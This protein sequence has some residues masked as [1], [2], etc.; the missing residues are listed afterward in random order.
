MSACNRW[1]QNTRGWPDRPKHVVKVKPDIEKRQVKELVVCFNIQTPGKFSVTSEQQKQTKTEDSLPM[2]T[3][4][5]L[6]Q[7]CLSALSQPPMKM[8]HNMN[9]TNC[10]RGGFNTNIVWLNKSKQNKAPKSFCRFATLAYKCV[11]NTYLV[12]GHLNQS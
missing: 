8:T 11:L 6:L 3:T 10:N 2:R 12:N 4:S 9:P 5:C 1:S 7:P